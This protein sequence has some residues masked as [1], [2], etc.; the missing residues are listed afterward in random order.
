MARKKLVTADSD[1]VDAYV[2]NC[3]K[4]AQSKL[5]TPLKSPAISG[6]PDNLTRAMTMTECLL[7]FGLQKSHLGLYLRPPTIK[8]HDKE[9]SDYST[10][11][12]V[13]RFPLDE[14]LPVPLVKKLVKASL[15]IMKEKAR[16]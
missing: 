10:T 3:Q 4:D 6:C 7:G 8:N 11:K 9:L 13:V 1:G 2:A 12:T 15:R 5:Q 16:K 14:K